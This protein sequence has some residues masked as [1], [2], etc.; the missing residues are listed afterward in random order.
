MGTTVRL[1]RR[2][3]VW[4]YRDNEW[5]EVD[6]QN[7]LTWLKSFEKKETKGDTWVRDHLD[8]YKFLSHYSWEQVCHY[9]NNFDEEEPRIT[10]YDDNG[11]KRYSQSISD[12]VKDYIREENYS[13][14]ISDAEYADD[15][16]EDWNIFQ[17]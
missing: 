6:Y 13:A 1:S 14:D 17:K 11:E 5:T 2:E 12:L 8:E 4:E 15:Y 3:L 10:Y 16:D 7:L 9:I